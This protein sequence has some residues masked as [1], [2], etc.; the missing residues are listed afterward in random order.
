M[1]YIFVLTYYAVSDGVCYQ[2]FIT[3]LYNELT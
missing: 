3:I 1:A 2:N